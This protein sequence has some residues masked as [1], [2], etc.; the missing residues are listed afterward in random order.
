MHT[1]ADYDASARETIRFGIS[2]T[3]TDPDAD[4]PRVGYY[5]LGTNRFTALNQ[6]Q[7]RILTHFIPDRGESYV[8]D[9]P[10]STYTRWPQ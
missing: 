7:T 8:R 3:Y 5:A 10:D 9:L 2:F 1:V 6:S 4:V